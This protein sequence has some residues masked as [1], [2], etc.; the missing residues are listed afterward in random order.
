MNGQRIM[1]AALMAGLG[2]AS[3]SSYVPDPMRVA[4]VAAKQAEHRP[5]IGDIPPRRAV[6]L[7][8]NPGSF[9]LG[10]EIKGSNYAIVM[11]HLVRIDS[12][13]GRILSILRPLP[14]GRQ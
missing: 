8:G 11:G 7:I 14:T 2:L 10:S 5:I 6:K 3:L 12:K 13:S 4:P 1:V 9:G